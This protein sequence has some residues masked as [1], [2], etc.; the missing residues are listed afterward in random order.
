[1]TRMLDDTLV[2]RLLTF[3]PNKTGRLVFQHGTVHRSPGKGSTLTAW[4]SG[5]GLPERNVGG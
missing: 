4:R 1:M 3:L 5:G 2:D